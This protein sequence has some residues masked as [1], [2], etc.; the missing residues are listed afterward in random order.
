MLLGCRPGLKDTVAGFGVFPWPERRAQ[1]RTMPQLIHVGV[2]DSRFFLKI[3]DAI[4]EV[5]VHVPR[6]VPILPETIIPSDDL[7]DSHQSGLSHVVTRCK[8]YR[9]A[10]NCHWDIQ[11]MFAI[12]LLVHVD[13]RH[14][15]FF[16]FPRHESF[17]NTTL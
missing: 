11:P 3:G 14:Q 2:G 8:N 9:I 12:C 16:Q 5:L 13:Q 7:R 17:L 1:R 6:L 4:A 10:M 15:F